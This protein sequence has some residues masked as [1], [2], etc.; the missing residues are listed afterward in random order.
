MKPAVQASR[1]SNRCE[2]PSVPAGV[3]RMACLP[4]ATPQSKTPARIAPLPPP[5]HHRKTLRNF[6]ADIVGGFRNQGW[7]HTVEPC[8]IGD[9]NRRLKKKRRKCS[10]PCKRYWHRGISRTV[11]QAEKLQ[12]P[13]VSVNFQLILALREVDHHGV[14]AERLAE[15][16]ALARVVERALQARRLLLTGATEPNIQ[17]SGP[18][19]ESA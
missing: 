14:Y 11:R 16:I 17:N 6:T 5:G 19:N 9:C 7:R 2:T 3:H 1:P 10:R 18:A 12:A 15:E 4:I 8:G 13:S